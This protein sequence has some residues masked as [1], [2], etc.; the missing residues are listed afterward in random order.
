[1][2]PSA[3]VFGCTGQD[4]SYLCKSLLDNNFSVYGTSRKTRPDLKRLVSLNIVDRVKI[5]CCDIEDF[6]ETKKII[7]KLRPT[8]IYNSK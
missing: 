1:M 5:I 2:K 3:I 6:K 8:E 7:K 4:G